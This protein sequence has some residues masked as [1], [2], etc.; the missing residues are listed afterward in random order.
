MIGMM[1]DTHDGQYLWFWE[2]EWHYGWLADRLTDICIL[3]SL[4]RLKTIKEY[5]KRIW[6]YRLI[7]V[8]IQN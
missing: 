4:Q 6:C 5:S 7:N 8:I 2:A 1:A 3:E